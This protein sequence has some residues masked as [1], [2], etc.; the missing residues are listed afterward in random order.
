[1]E[2]R[3]M[4]IHLLKPTEKRA[5]K[6]LKSIVD[7]KSIAFPCGT[8]IHFNTLK[9]NR[10]RQKK[11]QQIVAK[12]LLSESSPFELLVDL[13]DGKRMICDYM[14][15]HHEREG[16]NLQWQFGPVW[17]MLKLNPVRWISN[18]TRNPHTIFDWIQLW[19]NFMNNKAMM[20]S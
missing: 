13:F 20:K 4:E 1:M 2:R 3:M 19:A 14:P 11:R 18:F 8:G 9:T 5:W 6:N 17:E 7:N 12:M 15:F 10:R 16:I